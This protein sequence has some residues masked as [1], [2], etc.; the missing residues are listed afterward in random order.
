MKV[1]ARAGSIQRKLNVIVMTTTFFAL[2]LAGTAVV[3][4]DV[5]NQIATLKSDLVAQAD[6]VALASTSALTFDDPRVASENLA[7]LRARPAI[8]AAAIYNAQG[9]LFATFQSG[10]V[11][12]G[13]APE[14]APA[15]GVQLD[16]DWITVAR[17]VVSN[18]DTIGT[19]FLRARHDLLRRVLEYLGAL[20]AI[21]FTSL[22]A[23]LL[24]S[25]RLQTR[26]TG[27]ILAI[28]SVA[29][30]V[31]RSR[32]FNL[33][34]PRLSDDEVG[35]LADAFNDMLHELGKRAGT[36]EE[37]NLALLESDQRYQLAVRGSSAG[38][39]DWDMLADT[40]VF[41]PR[42]REMLGY[43][44]AQFP[45][46]PESIRKVLHPDEHQRIRG[47]LRGHLRDGREY[48]FECRLRT[49]AG[50][51]RWLSI[52]GVALKQGDGKPYRM[53]GSMVDITERKAAEQTL[54][55][56]SRAKDEFIATLA[57]ELRNPLAP[58]R[59]GLEILKKDT[60]NGPPSQRARAII[61]RQ[62]VH[63]IR[64]IDDLLDISRISSGKIRLEK[65]RISLR[66]VIE[67]AVETSR[68]GI[69]AGRHR[70][71]LELPAEEVEFDGDLTRLAQSLANLLNNAAKYTP[72]GGSI[73][74]RASRDGEQ[75]VIRVQDS[76]VG[77]PAEMLDRVFQLFAQ[78][79]RTI[80][81]SQG[82]LGIGLSLVRSLVELHGGSVTAESEGTGRGSTFTL[83]VPCIPACVAP[84]LPDPTHAP[85]AAPVHE[86]VRVLLADDNVDAADTMSAVLEMSGHE[87]KTVY[88]GPE[89]LQAA[90]LFSPDVM[91]LDIGMPGM[92]GYQVAQQLRADARFDQ[93]LLVALTGWGSEN[94]RALALQSGFDH[95]LTKPV[96]HLALE[97][98]LRRAAHRR[99]EPETPAA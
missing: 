73:L 92:S 93:T 66:A 75:A 18:R 74:V 64:L 81:R 3:L 17:P 42:V 82:G 37:A 48:Q 16:R 31:V 91:L 67:S 80:D 83:R 89:A 38:L 45:D 62:L 96:D 39:W 2:L 69:E 84:L 58:I 76:G 54:H 14:R 55:E 72:S 5:R 79:G 85:A 33:R 90:P 51:W 52:A 87:V 9:Q 22:A 44:L 86:A 28:S 97:P 98:L 78:V 40:M 26:L 57:H 8:S 6:I 34:A 32:N 25:N 46:R 94:D 12:G 1:L 43:T 49:G 10:A 71:A 68:P 50:E 35:S 47:A 21:F 15:V 36:L 77:I 4:F 13:P 63:M 60:G 61:E 53:A 65:K 7:M 59:T 99:T 24:L 41:S 11:E 20:T 56:A 70:L 27:P 88:S 30:R 29:S 19:I 23:A 95:H